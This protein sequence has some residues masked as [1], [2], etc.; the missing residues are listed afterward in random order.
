[1]KNHDKN[2]TTVSL[3][4]ETRIS[5]RESSSSSLCSEK[6]GKFSEKGTSPADFFFSFYL[7]VPVKEIG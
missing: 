7:A 3:F 6:S 1:M 4:G 2:L 5:G